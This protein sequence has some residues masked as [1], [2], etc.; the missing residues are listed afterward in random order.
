[1]TTTKYKRRDIGFIAQEVSDII[2]EVV[3]HYDTVK[4]DG[5]NGY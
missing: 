5:E 3:Y 1:M 2:P 4:E